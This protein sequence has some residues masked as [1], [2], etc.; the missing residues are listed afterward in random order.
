MPAR[1]RP[2]I[3]DVARAAGVSPT[4]VSYVLSGPKERAARISGETAARIR[5]AVVELNYVAN[6]SARSLRLQRSNRVLFLGTRFSSL[7]SQLM[8]QSIEARITRHGL[9]LD[10]WIGAGPDHIRR[11]ILSLDQHAADGLIIETSD[12]AVAELRSAAASGHAIVA[13]GPSGPEPSFDVITGDYTGA[14]RD[15]IDHVT[16]RAYRHF[17]LLAAQSDINDHRIMVARSHLDTLGVSPGDVSIIHCPHDRI[18]ACQAARQFL[19]DVPA[20]VA[21]YA[22]SDVSAIGVLWACLAAGLRVPEDVAI[23]GH[24]N[25]PET[26]ITVPPL[27]SLGPVNSDYGP[28]ADLMATRLAHRSLPGRHISEPFQ[29]FTRSST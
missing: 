4:T 17:V 1:S 28:A 13:I 5:D 25:S 27:T 3:H 24:G 19:A 12:N 16:Q 23:I 8:A 15:A 18:A 26:S 29:L 14:I 6:Q 22:G 2:T 20:P 11:A 10:V 7:F 21:V 9:T